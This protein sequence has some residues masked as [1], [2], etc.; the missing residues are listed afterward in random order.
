[1]NYNSYLLL[2]SCL[3]I[4]SVSKC[5]AQPECIVQFTVPEIRVSV[6]IYPL[7]YLVIIQLLHAR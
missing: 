1:M 4:N 6:E 2:F 7:Q 5:M 3:T